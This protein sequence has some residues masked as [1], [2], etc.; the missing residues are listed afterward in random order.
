[1]HKL[2]YISQGHN[3]NEH[4]RNIESALQAGVKHVQ[5]R[6]KN[7]SEK[8]ILNCAHEIKNKCEKYN[9]FFTLNDSPQIAQQV[10]ANGLHLGLKDMPLLEAQKIFKGKIGATANEFHQIK[11]HVQNKAD[12]VGLGPLRFT[13]T[14]ENLSPILG[15][16][17]FTKIMNQLKSEQIN[18]PVFAIGGIELKDI[19]GLMQAGVYG[20]AV[21]GLITNATHKKEIINQ[22]NSLLDHAYDRKQRV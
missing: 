1:M 14:K 10:R 13:S 18:I 12:Y 8:E 9:A 2:I 17:G 16:E 21:S 5:L 19:E 7:C 22:I 3:P 4:L 6:L 15:I 20:I 11:N